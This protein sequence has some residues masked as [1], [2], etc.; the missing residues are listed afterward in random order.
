MT[1]DLASALEAL[2]DKPMTD[3]ELI[4]ALEAMGMETYYI[5]GDPLYS[6]HDVRFLVQKLEAAEAELSAETVRAEKAQR[7]VDFAALWAWRTDPPNANNVLTEGERL[8][9]IKYHPTIKAVW[10]A[11]LNKDASHG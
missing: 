10:D 2:G 6:L 11:A 4:A 1:D 8:S 3:A 5:C 9:A 7:A